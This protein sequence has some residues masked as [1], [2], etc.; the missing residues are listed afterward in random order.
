MLH[1]KTPYSGDIVKDT[2]KACNGF[3]FLREDDIIAEIHKALVNRIPE[4]KNV[5]TTLYE[6]ACDRGF[7]HELSDSWIEVHIE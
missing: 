2:L 3:I 5:A 1:C 7:I 4:L 6:A